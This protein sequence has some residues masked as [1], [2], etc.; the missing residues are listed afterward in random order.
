MAAEDES[1]YPKNEG[2]AEPEDVLLDL[3][4]RADSLNQEEFLQ[5]LHQ[6]RNSEAL[7]SS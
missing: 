6:Q 4:N 5:E 1:D 3:L 2:A 7:A